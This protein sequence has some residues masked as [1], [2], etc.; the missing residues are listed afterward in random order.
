[1]LAECRAS[2]IRKYSLFI[3]IQQSCYLRGPIVAE[4]SAS[5]LELTKEVLYTV[6]LVSES[7]NDG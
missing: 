2:Y 4:R 3:I 7:Y 6:V 1:M 5:L